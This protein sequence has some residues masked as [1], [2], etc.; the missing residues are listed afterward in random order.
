MYME[1]NILGAF[2]AFSPARLSETAAVIRVMQKKNISISQF[3]KAVDEALAAKKQEVREDAL[4]SRIPN[5]K[6][7]AKQ[8]GKP[9]ARRTGSTTAR[10]YPRTMTCPKCGQTA[11]AQPVCPG[12]AKGRAGIR[13]EYICGEC[14]FAFY[15]D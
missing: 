12:C 15:L 1:N 2:Q 11:Y 14:N 3:L 4:H 6:S 13:R 8:A 5:H 7:A 10:R 9:A